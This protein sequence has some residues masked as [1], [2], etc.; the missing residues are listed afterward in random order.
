MRDGLDIAIDLPVS[1]LTAAVGGSVEVPTP[2]GVAELKLPAGT[3]NGKLFRLRGKG[4]PSLRGLGTGDLV[5][6][7][8]F[9]VPQRLTSKQR[10][11]I[12]D[13]VRSLGPENFPEAQKLSSAMKIFYARKEKLAK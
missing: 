6:R 13:L 1:P 7:V 8:I 4:M 11:Q 10:G 2:E 5:V 3:P 12:D 9:E